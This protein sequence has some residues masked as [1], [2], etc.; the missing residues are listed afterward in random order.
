MYE[1]W[2]HSSNWSILWEGKWLPLNAPLF[3]SL[4]YLGF[5]ET[6]TWVAFLR[7]QMFGESLYA[8]GMPQAVAVTEQVGEC[9]CVLILESSPHISHGWLPGAKEAAG[10]TGCSL[11]IDCAPVQTT[12]VPCD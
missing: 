6:M 12:F 3:H 4:S 2:L 10:H 7:F 1:P 11:G 5:W 8:Q 9:C